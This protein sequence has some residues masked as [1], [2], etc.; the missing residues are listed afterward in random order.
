MF[1]VAEPEVVQSNG[2][3]SDQPQ[4]AVYE[5]QRIFDKEL[6]FLFGVAERMWVETGVMKH[7]LC[8]YTQRR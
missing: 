7:Q 3:S 2:I 5:A 4:S 8:R 1:G 6:D